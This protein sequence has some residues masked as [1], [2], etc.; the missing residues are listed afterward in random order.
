MGMGI[1]L[2]NMQIISKWNEEMIDLEEKL[3]LK[4]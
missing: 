4:R 1:I 3:I 2:K